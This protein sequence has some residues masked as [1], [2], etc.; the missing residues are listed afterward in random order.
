[1]A[2][3][4][5]IVPTHDRAQYAVPTIRYL[6]DTCHDAE[7]VVADS[8]EEDKLTDGLNDHPRFSQVRLLRPEKRPMSVVDNFN[9]GLRHSTGDYLVFL[10]DDDFVMPIVG[11]VCDW[12]QS[13]DIDVVKFTF[14][15]LYFWPDFQHKRLAGSL[16]GTLHLAPF[17]GKASIYDPRKALAEALDNFGGGV[18][19]MPRAYAGMVS[20]Q[21][22][23]RIA[24]E[25]GDLFG[26][27]SPDIY[28]SALISMCSS[29]CVYLDYPV[30]IPGASSASTAGQSANGQ[31][32]GKLREN[33]HIAPFTDLV[34]DARIPEFYSVPTV[35][36]FSLLKAVEKL[37]IKMDRV[38][39]MRLYLKCYLYHADYRSVTREAFRHSR[40]NGF[41]RNA[42]VSCAIAL[43][44]ESRWVFG[45]IVDRIARRFKAS[46]IDVLVDVQD[47]NAARREIESRTG[48][49]A[50]RLPNL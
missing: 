35:W 11:D 6:L 26:G 44:R 48:R 7:I 39:F 9:F 14:P 41:L 18:M 28:S 4:S 19:D 16:G 13:N 5:I 3:L 32:I 40:E 36:S 22:V 25:Y 21:L 31:H 45:K 50:Y 15:A 2:K 23:Q 12:M 24:N 46:K 49:V 33:A 43:L 29:K 38:N 42:M 8:S 10:G 1:M 47:L 17:T 27:V 30:L 37:G 34:W 20:R